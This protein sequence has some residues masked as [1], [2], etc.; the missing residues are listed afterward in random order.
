MQQKVGVG[1]WEY[2]WGRTWLQRV[3]GLHHP[4]DLRRSRAAFSWQPHIRPQGITPIGLAWVYMFI[5]K[6]I[7]MATGT[8]HL[9]PTSHG[10]V[11]VD[12]YSDA[13]SFQ[14]TWNWKRE[15]PHRKEKSV[16]RKKGRE[17][18]WIDEN[19]VSSLHSFC[20]LPLSMKATLGCY[21]TLATICLWCTAGTWRYSIVF[22]KCMN[23]WMFWVPNTLSYGRGNTVSCS[24]SLDVHIGAIGCCFA[25]PASAIV[26][27]NGFLKDLCGLP[28]RFIKCSEEDPKLSLHLAGYELKVSDLPS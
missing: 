21:C 3:L 17:R 14:T 23:E 5:P 20:L 28:N 25:F 24:K 26:A 15:L 11:R 1:G 12:K 27:T 19:N 9:S 22:D 4:N 18:W 8:Y 7:T 16:A 13:C 2:G 10:F 6:I